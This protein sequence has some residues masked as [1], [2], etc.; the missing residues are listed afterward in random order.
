M[1]ERLAPETMTASLNSAYLSGLTTIVNYITNTKGKT[2]PDPK[3]A[4]NAN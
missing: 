3:T 1:M 2:S 4:R